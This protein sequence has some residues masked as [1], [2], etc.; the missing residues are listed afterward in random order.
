MRVNFADAYH[1]N[2]ST[3]RSGFSVLYTVFA[4]PRYANLEAFAFCIFNTPA[5]ELTI[6]IHF[7]CYACRR[8]R[9]VLWCEIAATAFV[10]T[11]Y[12][13]SYQKS[14]GLPSPVKLL[15]ER[16]LKTANQ[17]VVLALRQS[18]PLDR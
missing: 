14:A 17:R 15:V 2:S 10:P 1:R 12:C 8:R 5:G 7:L 16:R 3:N 13:V 4:L 11:Q 18:M 9:P 6:S